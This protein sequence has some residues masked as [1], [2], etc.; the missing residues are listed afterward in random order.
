[1]N[2]S[3]VN[4][5]NKRITRA[6]KQETQDFFW[7][8]SYQDEQQAK[9]ELGVNKIYEQQLRFGLDSLEDFS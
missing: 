5:K 2:K 4:L 3:E 1:M 9:E 7:Y 6:N 8:N